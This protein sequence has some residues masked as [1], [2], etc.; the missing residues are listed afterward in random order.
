MLLSQEAIYEAHDD[1]VE[2]KKGNLINPLV[3]K[4][5]GTFTTQNI[6]TIPDQ[7]MGQNTGLKYTGKLNQGKQVRR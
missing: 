4:Q 5:K 7:G 6:N 2:F 3:A 1:G